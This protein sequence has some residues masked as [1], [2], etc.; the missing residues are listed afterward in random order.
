MKKDIRQVYEQ[1]RYTR[2]PVLLDHQQKI[3]GILN[4]K[5]LDLKIKKEQDW[6]NFIVKKINY[7]AVD[8]KLNSTANQTEFNY[9]SR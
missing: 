5:T 2:Y 9:S 6:R 8:T 4:F 3:M 7:S 1:Y